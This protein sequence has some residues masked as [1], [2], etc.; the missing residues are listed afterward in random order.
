MSVDI[1]RIRQ[2]LAEYRKA[3][4]AQQPPVYEPTTAD[5]KAVFIEVRNVILPAIVRYTKL[6]NG[7]DRVLDIDTAKL[8]AQAARLQPVC[9]CDNDTLRTSARFLAGAVRL[10]A[11]RHEYDAVDLSRR[12]YLDTQLAIMYEEYEWKGR[13]V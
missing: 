6:V 13:S 3:N 1:E 8:E 4:P 9:R 11:K 7:T 5:M 2:E 10:I 12:L